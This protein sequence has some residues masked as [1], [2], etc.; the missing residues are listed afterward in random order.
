MAT[1]PTFIGVNGHDI[2]LKKKINQETPFALNVQ[3]KGQ[4]GTSLKSLNKAYL[5][6]ALHYRAQG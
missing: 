3:D 1:G 6:K 4:L 2:Q 5:A